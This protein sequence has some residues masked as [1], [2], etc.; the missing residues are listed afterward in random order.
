MLR[1]FGNN[2]S[3]DDMGLFETN[4]KALA[5]NAKNK[6]NIVNSISTLKRNRTE[7]EAANTKTLAQLGRDID[8]SSARE[9]RGQKFTSPQ[10]I[11]DTSAKQLSR[12]IASA[13]G[14]GTST[15]ETPTTNVDLKSVTE[16]YL[17]NK[18]A[19]DK[20][21]TKDKK[22]VKAEPQFI[23]YNDGKGGIIADG[24]TPPLTYKGDPS[25]VNI[26]R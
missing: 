5:Q 20:A 15:K 12:K 14:N 17:A 24:Y 25:R 19:K 11:A 18:K 7:T 4:V 23:P 6:N 13:V 1:L 9:N 16:R 22:E 10:T 21:S 8:M 26:S 3:P 2:L